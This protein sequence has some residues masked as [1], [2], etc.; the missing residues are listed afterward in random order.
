MMEENKKVDYGKN[1]IGAVKSKM[2]RMFASVL[3]AIEEQED[4]P[5][6]RKKLLDG[7]NGIIKLLDLVFTKI[8][9][10]PVDAIV[11]LEEDVT[12]KDNNESK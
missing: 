12:D 4:F 1:V 8:E 6:I 11:N 2:N 10:T 9:I 7:G 3:S 5:I